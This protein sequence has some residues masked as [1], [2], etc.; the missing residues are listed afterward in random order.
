MQHRFSLGFMPAAIARRGSLALAALVGLALLCGLAALKA[1][2][3]AAMKLDLVQW[4]AGAVV[5]FVLA[6]QR[7]QTDL[8]ERPRPGNGAF[9][10]AGGALL[11]GQLIWD[12]LDVEH[13]LPFPSLA[14]AVFLMAGPALFIGLLAQARP[15]MAGLPWCPVLLDTAAATLGAFTACLSLFLPA[16]GE[17]VVQAAA[18]AAYPL[19]FLA[20]AVLGLVIALTRRA[21]PT[22]PALLLPAAALAL[23]ILWVDWNLLFLKHQIR[24]GSVLGLLFTLAYIGT[25]FGIR[26]YELPRG[27]SVRWERICAA[28]LRLLPLAMVVA[29]AL[30]GT[31]LRPRQLGSLENRVALVG[32]AIVVLLAMVRQ[33]FLLEAHDEVVATARER[34]ERADELERRVRSRTE[35]LAQATEQANAANRAKSEFLANMSHEMRTPLNSVLGLSF[36]ALQSKQLPREFR[37]HFERILASGSHLLRLIDDVLQMSRLEAGRVELEALPFE[38]PQVIAD[39]RSQMEVLAREKGL[40]LKWQVAPEARGPF[41]GDAFRLKQILLNLVANAVKFTARGEVTVSAKA[42]FEEVD[43]CTLQI[44]VCDTGEGI[45]PQEIERIFEPFQQVD[46]STTRRHGGSGLGLAITRRLLTA[47]GGQIHVESERGKGS[48][49]WFT[50]RLPRARAPELPAAVNDMAVPSPVRPGL[51]V[52]LVEDDETN[53]LV[54]TAMLERLRAQVSVAVTGEQAVEQLKQSRFDC[55]LMDIQMPGM[56][57]LQV[58][59]WARGEGRLRSLPIIAMTANVFDEDR[60]AC[61]QAGMNDFIAKP[62]EPRHLAAVLARWAGDAASGSGG[63]DAAD[64]LPTGG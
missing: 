56:D 12:V 37:G 62:F 52:L 30:G 13:W 8:R 49:F 14:D 57:G 60:R 42:S 25:G 48:R 9:V 18:L 55:V 41:I 46:N 28:T 4:T 53:R 29:A 10:F 59:R 26:L 58:T 54:A 7:W 17:T 2:A 23:G 22:L 24:A 64:P 27:G 47:M 6:R 40:R 36:L 5:A 16:S 44:E 19:V 45:A 43:A 32:A 15:A 33:S 63:G 3:A 1:P 31:G 11:V 20:P 39:V 34:K 21:R 51:R 38:L 50:V 35:Q 61:H